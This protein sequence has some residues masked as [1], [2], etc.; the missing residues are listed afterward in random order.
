VE[1][2]LALALTALVAAV[3]GR[4][5][6][7]TLTNQTDVERRA[8]ELDREAIV[9]GQLEEDFAGILLGLPGDAAPVAVFGMPRPVLQL[10]T[11]AAIPDPGA[12]LHTV[13]RPAL[14]HY[15]LVESHDDPQQLNLV[16]ELIDRTSTSA[17]P[18]REA[19]GTRVADFQVEILNK[20]QWV[21]GYPPADARLADAQAVRVSLRWSNKPQ[22]TVRTFLVQHAR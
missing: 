12:A 13:R 8:R 15:R 11:L 20:G 17:T 1:M 4:I 6:V 19:I 21:A 16:R 22:S 14:V 3:T 9:L 18:A 5:A 10:S 7:Q 2:L